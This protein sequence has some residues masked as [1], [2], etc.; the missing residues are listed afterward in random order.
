M[1]TCQFQNLPRIDEALAGLSGAI[2]EDTKLRR[3]QM[4]LNPIEGAACIYSK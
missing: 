4:V 3:D 1:P 2:E